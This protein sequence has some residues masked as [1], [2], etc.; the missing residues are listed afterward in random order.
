[1]SSQAP[2]QTGSRYLAYHRQQDAALGRAGSY[3]SDRF[4]GRGIVICAGGPRYFTCA[5]VLVRVL[6]EILG[7]SLPIQVWHRGPQEMDEPMRCLLTGN[8]A[9]VVDASTI[10]SLSSPPAGWAFKPYAMLHCSFQELVLLDADNIP[11][12]DPAFLFET[13]QYRETGAL[14]WPDLEPLPST[15]DIW[16]ICRV[17]YRAEPSFES[18]QIV[19]DKARCWRALSLTAHLNARGDFYYR[20]IHGDKDTFH[21]AWRFLG[22]PYSMAPHP[23]RV[24]V[25]DQAD[26]LFVYLGLVLGQRDFEGRIVF[27]HRNTPK[28]TLF[29]CNPRF[30][31]FRY[32]AECFQFLDELARFWSGRV[33]N[34]DF[35]LPDCQTWTAGSRWFRYVRTSVD[36]RLI[37]LRSDQ[38]IGFGNS[39]RER[40][41]RMVAEREW[42]VLEIFGDTYLTCRL[43]RGG[44]GIWRGRWLRYERMP[45]ELIPHPFSAT[46]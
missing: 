14:F 46:S 2:P 19:I 21:M 32:E 37:E 40:T 4:Q 26:P 9:E 17:A 1:M 38:R 29:G 31:E 16:E 43:I 30:P 27:Q 20:H 13:P 34:L 22:Q 6:R 3:P 25:D 8:G 7:T 35:H 44:D 12:V 33:S 5:W 36:E 42:S 23:P 11:T 41:W 28:F 15:S 45:I 10:G 18:G 24:L 39:D